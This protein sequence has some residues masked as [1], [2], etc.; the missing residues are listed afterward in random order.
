MLETS[1]V[2]I[3]ILVFSQ[4][5]D[6][7]NI[8]ECTAKMDKKCHWCRIFPMKLGSRYKHDISLKSEFGD[9]CKKSLCHYEQTAISSRPEESTN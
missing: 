8:Q 5:G 7:G 1:I 4:I 3:V 2:I 9:K 6:Y